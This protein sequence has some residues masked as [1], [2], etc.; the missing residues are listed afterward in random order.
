MD[1][2]DLIGPED[3][4]VSAKAT[5]KKQVLQDLAD[6]ASKKTGISSREIFDTLLERERLVPQRKP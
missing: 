2:A 3:V 1:L 5:C 4:L 6:R